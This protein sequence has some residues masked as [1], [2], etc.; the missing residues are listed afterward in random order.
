MRYWS[1]PSDPSKANPRARTAVRL[2][3]LDQTGDQRPLFSDPAALEENQKARALSK[4]APEAML[5]S[6]VPTDRGPG[7]TDAPD[8]GADGL[9]SGSVFVKH[10]DVNVSATPT[11]EELDSAFGTNNKRDGFVGTIADGGGNP[12]Y[13][14]SSNGTHWYFERLTK[15]V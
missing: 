15:A 7:G 6:V 3:S 8:R 14:V 13:I 11:S 10:V 9:Q 12:M 2:P 4:M 5:D 1:R